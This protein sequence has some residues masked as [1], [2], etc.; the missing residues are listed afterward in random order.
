MSGQH[1]ILADVLH[2]TVSG[3][4]Y[5]MSAKD[6]AFAKVKAM[7][8]ARNYVMA[9]AEMKVATVETDGLKIKG[10][11]LSVKGAGAGGANVRLGEVYIDAYLHAKH[12]GNAQ[13]ELLDLFMWN[14]AKNPDPAARDGLSDF[15]AQARMP[16]TDRGTFLAYRYSNSNFMDCR[17]GKMENM[18]G[19][20]VKMRRQ[21]CDSNPN[22]DCSRGLH[23]CHHS[24]MNGNGAY[25][26]VVEIN[27]RD[28]VAVPSKYS[29]TKMRVC[30]FRPLCLL[31]YFKERLLIAE[32]AALGKVP[33]FMTEQTREWECTTGVPKHL[34]DRYKPVDAWE[35]AAA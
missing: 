17:T 24:Y 32:Q 29:Y 31:S 28:V 30:R 9:E 15:L 11:I 27:P 8:L 33:V 34:L 5:S 18:I 4:M 10:N 14:V 7:L 19:T 35:W 16:I 2:F 26:C 13:E 12:Q 21:D 3:R 20:D 22:A 1:V 23:A 25:Q 6:I